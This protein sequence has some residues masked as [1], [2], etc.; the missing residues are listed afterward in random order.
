MK[1]LSAEK[2]QEA[3]KYSIEQQGI[4]SLELMERAATRVFNEIHS[5]LQNAD[6]PIKIF[7]G[8][9]NNGGDGLV[10]ARLLLKQ[11]YRPEV[12][13][14]NFTQNRSE[15]F[16]TNLT[17]LEKIKNAKIAE[18]DEANDIPEISKGDFVVDAIFGI[19]LSRKVSGIAREVI[20]KVNESKAFV[21]A[22]DMPSGLFSDKIPEADE[23]V[24][25][26][27]FTL[28]FQ[29]PK[30]VFYLPQTM[31]YIGQVKILDIGLDRKFI[32]GA[33]A[34]AQLIGIKEAACLY[35]ER[36]KN[37]H[38]GDFGHSLVI[39]GSYGKM[40][41]VVLSARA[42]LRTGSGLCTVFSPSCG[43][44]ILQ[45]GIPEVMTLSDKNEKV[46][47]H[48][49]FDLD[50]DAICFGMGAGTKPAVQTAFEEFLASAKS[51]LLIDADGINILSKKSELLK[52]LPENS[53][54][55]PHPGELKRLLGK[56]ED[57][58][59]KIHKV[60]AFVK[61]HKLILV[62]K[63]AHTFIFNKDRI[64]INNSG[65]AGMATAG[66][67]DVLSGVITGLL[68]QK[69]EPLQAAIFGVFLHGLSGDL[70]TAKISEE[71]LIASDIIEHLG[72]AYNKIRNVES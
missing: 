56:W 58:F 47:S 67:G 7:C 8:P 46:L 41:S 3:D 43:Y 71:S 1:I 26:A 33:E 23:A 57:D 51:P 64:Y 66:S 36:Q 68:S 17:R 16:T 70:A 25:N 24:I 29:C 31:N 52:L 61:K 13:I 37:S 59:D 11:N 21:L 19:G 63:G 34:Q 72:D 45:I 40:G 6:I 22:I 15:D 12:F 28:S 38:K 4:Q 65:N 44:E 35:K 49:K 60:Q 14:V 55:T 42:V 10:I 27:E 53:I 5:R 48:I 32:A 54:L 39:G 62:L 9:G 20:N 69:Y 50:P 30:M 18:I 2:L